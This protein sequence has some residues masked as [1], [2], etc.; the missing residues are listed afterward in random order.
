M[1]YNK[2]SISRRGERSNGQADERI[3]R[4]R[5]ARFAGFFNLYFHIRGKSAKT[6]HEYYLDLRLFFRVLKHNKGAVDKN[7]PLD[8]IDISDI[9]LDFIRDITLSDTYD[10]LEYM[11]QSRP[12]QQNSNHTNYGLSVNSR[13]R[14]VSAIRAFFRYLTDK[15]HV[16]EVNPVS[17]LEAPTVRKSLPTYLTTDDSVQPWNPS[18]AR[19]PSEITAS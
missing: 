6:A 17:G 18:P 12:T 15:Q 2:Y 4:R 14:K 11:A 7:L 16:L 13:A 3:R 8:E 9:D 1:R 10:Y 5:T 19:M